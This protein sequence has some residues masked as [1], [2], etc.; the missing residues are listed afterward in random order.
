MVVVTI[1]FLVDRFLISKQKTEIGL[2]LVLLVH[3]A[4]FSAV[5]YGP[6]NDYSA[7]EEGLRALLSGTH[8]YGGNTRYLLNFPIIAGSLGLVYRIRRQSFRLVLIN[9][10]T[11]PNSWWFSV[12]SEQLSLQ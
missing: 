11:P 12:C 9:R 5:T 6:L 1:C 4:F 10:L 8:I 3:L 7:Y 2:Y